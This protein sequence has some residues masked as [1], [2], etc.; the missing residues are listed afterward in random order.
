MP[1]Q[2]RDAYMLPISPAKYRT[3]PCM[4]HKVSTESA[5]SMLTIFE[6]YKAHPAAFSPLSLHEQMKRSAEYLKPSL[7]QIY[8]IS[9]PS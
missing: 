4:F 9:T 3:V 8:D 6:L 5:E 1:W 7:F 2:S